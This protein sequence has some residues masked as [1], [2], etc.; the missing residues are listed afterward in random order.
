M[1]P[2]PSKFDITR[3][4][5]ERVVA[6]FYA[7]VR[8]HPMLGPVFAVHISDWPKHEAKVANFWANAILYERSYD[9]NPAQVHQ[10]A[11]NVR[12]GMFESW[13]AVFDQTLQTELRPEQAAAWS[14]LAHRIGGSLRASVVDRDRLAGGIPKLR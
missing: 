7:A 4:D 9:G 14:A 3:P 12:P 2:L 10:R 8:A 13:L 11:E 6:V 1:A 5:I